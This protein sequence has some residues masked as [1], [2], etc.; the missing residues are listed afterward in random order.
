MEFGGGG[1]IPQL[2]YGFIFHEIFAEEFHVLCQAK[3]TVREPAQK[4]II[5]R[6][7]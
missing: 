2:L 1:V 3:L 5:I 4:K 6:K 7:Q